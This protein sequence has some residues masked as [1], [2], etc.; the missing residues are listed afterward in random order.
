MMLKTLKLGII[1]IF[2]IDMLKISNTAKISN[3][4]DIED[5][6]RGSII[7][8]KNNVTIDSFVKIKPAG[9]VG[10]LIIDD[11]SYINSGTV[12]YTGNGVYIGKGT[13]VAANCTFAPMNHEYKSRS[14]YIKDQGFMKSKGGIH[15]G[16]DV[17][18]GANCIILDGSRIGDGCV[19]GAGSIVRGILDDYSVYCGT[20]LKKI[21]ERS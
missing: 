6:V 16:N 9:G 8:I 10:N 15:V 19:I 3:L 14:D 5:S 20:P 12:I 4:S 2:Q 11:S 17:W 18:I 7:E 1:I 13:L 21:N